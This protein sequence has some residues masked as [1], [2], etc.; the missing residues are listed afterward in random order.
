MLER[1]E[2]GSV[3]SRAFYFHRI[4]F[5][6]GVCTGAIGVSVC[7]LWARVYVRAEQARKSNNG[8]R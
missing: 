7:V 2:N 3:G 1:D 8:V 6:G 5:G 4:D